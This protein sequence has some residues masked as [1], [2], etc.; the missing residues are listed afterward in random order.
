MNHDQ[1]FS[2][3]TLAVFPPV[4][5]P[6]V[7]TAARVFEAAVATN[8]AFLYCVPAFLEVRISKYHRRI[9]SYRSWLFVKVWARDSSRLADLQKFKSVVSINYVV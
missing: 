5:P 9:V 8:V 4:V 2:G 6:V 1:M 7:P 3:I